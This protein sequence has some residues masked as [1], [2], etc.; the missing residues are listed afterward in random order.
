MSALTFE[1]PRQKLYES[2]GLD[3]LAKEVAWLKE[4]LSNE[5]YGASKASSIVKDVV[6]AHQDLLS[7]NIL[8]N[9]SWDRVQLIDF[10]YGGYNF[11]GFDIANHFCEHCGF[12]P[13]YV[14][15]YPTKDTQL[16]FFRA[17]FGALKGLE[18]GKSCFGLYVRVWGAKSF[19]VEVAPSNRAAW[20]C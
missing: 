15:A 6:F 4:K 14:N 8:H 12:D 3:N 19:M 18:L 16:H 13:D 11:R 7:G 17:Y 10:E 9:P 2:L 20:S 5:S 1:G